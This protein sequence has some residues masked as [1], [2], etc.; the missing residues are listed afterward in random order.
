MNDNTLTELDEL[1]SRAR[2]DTSVDAVVLLTT[3]ALAVIMVV[4]NLATSLSGWADALH[5]VGSWLLAVLVP[6]ALAGMWLYLRWRE[7]RRGA[8]RQSR[9]VGWTALWAAI[10]LFVVGLGPLL[11]VVLGPY[12]VL[13]GLV[14]LAGVRFSSR[15]LL[16][17][18]LVA[19]ALGTWAGMYQSNN[20]FGLSS[21]DTVI[22]VAIALA[23][24]L[25]G[26]VVAVRQRRR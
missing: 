12:P 4:L 21:F 7:S 5:G 24:L 9:T 3:G 11:T 15:L 20:R 17:W 13:M 22:G 26:A 2:R 10:I 19:A 18:G 25:A 14:A 6:L 16:V 23:T 8:G 1:A